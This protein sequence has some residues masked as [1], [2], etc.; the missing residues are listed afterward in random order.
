MENEYTHSSK[1]KLLRLDTLIRFRVSSDD[2]RLIKAAAELQGMLPSSWLRA[3]VMQVA[4]K[5]LG[6]DTRSEAI[7]MVAKQ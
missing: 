5:D 6:V 1:S 7:D 2:D 4:L 3:A